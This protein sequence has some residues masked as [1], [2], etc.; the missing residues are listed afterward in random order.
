MTDEVRKAPAVPGRWAWPK[1]FGAF[2]RMWPWI[3]SPVAALVVI[4][5][6]GA[7][8]RFDFAGILGFSTLN[9]GWLAF[10]VVGGVVLAWRL[11]RPAAGW[12]LPLRIL[13]APVTAYLVCFVLVTITGLIFL[14]GQSLLET[15]TTDAPG[16][17]IWVGLAVLI[18]SCICEAIR[19]VIRAIRRGRS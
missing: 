17:S 7:T 19:A 14:P 2:V 10:C 11:A 1:S 4:G 8:R 16:R 12:R 9:Y 5:A 6:V 3:S 15:V 13:V 18:G